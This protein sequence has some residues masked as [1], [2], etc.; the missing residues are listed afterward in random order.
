MLSTFRRAISSWLMLGVLLLAVIAI[1]VTGFGTDGMG[2]MGTAGGST[3]GEQIATVDGVELY[4]SQLTEEIN[5][6]FRRAQQEQPELDLA[7][8]L[9]GGAFEGIL[10]QLIMSQALLRYADEHGIIVSERMIDREIVNVPTFRNLAGQFDQQV[11]L[12][13]LNRMGMTEQ[14]AREDIRRS[15]IQ[16][17]LVLP[18]AGSGRMPRAIAEQYAGLLLERR[19]GMI[20][21]VPSEAMGA[22]VEPTEQELAAHYRASRQRYTV[23][24]RRVLRYATIGQEQVAQA[25]Q[26]T[27]Q[28]IAAQYQQNAA[29]YGPQ[30]TRTLS[31]VVLPDQNAAN[32]FMQRLRG[33]ASFA[34]AA[35]AAGFGATDI[36]VGQ[37][38]RQQF[39]G[40]TNAQVAQAAFAAA[41]GATVG[42]IRSELGFH[43]VRIDA[44]NRTAGRPLA[45]VRAEIATQIQQRKSN[46]LLAALIA[47]I[48]ERLQGG[49]SFEEALRSER[50]TA[51]E[52]PPITA[53]GA[54]PGA[55][56]QATPD[57][58]RLLAPAFEMEA[59]Q[60]PV[61][62]TITENQ[63]YAVLAIGRVIPAAVPP[64]AEIRQLVRADLIRTRANER[65]RAVAAAIVARVN[66]GMT[67]QQAFAQA[68]VRLPPPQAVNA[69]RQQIAQNNQVP[70]PLALMFSLPQGAA[71]QL[72]APNG[73][74]WFVIHLQ[75]RIPGDPAS[76][77]QLV[78]SAQ[79]Q[80]SQLIGEE[81]AQEFARQVQNGLTVTRNEEAIGRV[82]QRL[83][84]VAGGQ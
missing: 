20:G 9:S 73:A 52:T 46:E 43:I 74:G 30:E 48:E 47:R 71:R 70:P 66:G 53:T 26:A 60:D 84:G 76:Q 61:V 11:F 80:F 5:R 51:V 19:Q 44:I 13:V 31:Q 40:T 8:F 55:Q 35:Q 27:E 42:P 10:N 67:M 59:D 65:A 56:F 72:Q 79:Q 50:L 6:A 4:E 78:Q 14:Q 32:Q 17:Q 23:P 75:R 57:L 58:Q 24:E 64:L 54:A 69:L 68:G 45:A 38:N 22:G 82:R 28:E 36:A 25:S 7:T 21:V 49:M 62:E 39:T 63:R 12:Q 83:V 1:V 3:K 29:T 33:G 41:Q 77:P 16:R 2:G 34:Q 37:Q 15:L 18:I 81:F